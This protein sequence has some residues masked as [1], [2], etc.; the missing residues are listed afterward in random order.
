MTHPTADVW[1]REPP[2]PLVG[3]C[4]V[5]QRCR[6]TVTQP[7]AWPRHGRTGYEGGPGRLEL[8][9]EQFL[10]DALCELSLVQGGN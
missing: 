5:R 6:G 7:Q 2:S 9:L 3:H 10:S 4:A 1:C 8:P